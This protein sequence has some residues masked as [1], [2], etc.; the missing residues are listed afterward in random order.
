MSGLKRCECGS[1]MG[2]F[3]YRDG[4]FAEWEC[5]ECGYNT[6]TGKPE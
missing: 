2:F 6:V 1:R 3:G 4:D 5:P